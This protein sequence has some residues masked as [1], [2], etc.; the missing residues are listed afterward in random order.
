[1]AGRFQQQRLC[2][3][4]RIDESEPVDRQWTFTLVRCRRCGLL[5]RFPGNTAPERVAYYQTEYDPGG[6]TTNLPSELELK[7]HM[8]ANFVGTSKDFSNLVA[9]LESLRVQPGARIFD[10]GANWGYPTY[11]LRCAGYSAAAF[12]ISVP[13]AAF[14]RNLGVDFRT[15]IDAVPGPFHVVYSSHVP[16]HV[17]DPSATLTVQWG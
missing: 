17:V 11:Q 5:F 13:R 2:P 9:L 16:E 8:D 12:E 6:L 4:C 14:G 15:S 1:M 7:Q 3:C 10:F